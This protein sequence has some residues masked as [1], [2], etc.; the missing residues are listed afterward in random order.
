MDA[1]ELDLSY[2]AGRTVKS[3]NTNVI[4]MRYHYIPFGRTKILT[5]ANGILNYIRIV[6]TGDVEHFFMCLFVIFI[7]SSVT[8]FFTS[9]TFS[10]FIGYFGGVCL[11]ALLLSFERFLYILIEVFV[12]YVLYNYFLSFHSLSFNFLIRVF[13]R[14]NVFNFDEVQITDFFFYGWYSWY[15]V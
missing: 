4:Q 2:I 12:R 7:S 13:L 9:F 3:G 15:H 11:L 5:I 6:T 10:N 8:C 14:A 1:E